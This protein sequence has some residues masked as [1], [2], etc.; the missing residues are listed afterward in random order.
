M[1]SSS[2]SERN[3]SNQPEDE[4]DDDRGEQVQQANKVVTWED[5]ND[6]AI[7]DSFY[8]PLQVDPDCVDKGN[9]QDGDPSSCWTPP[10]S[11]IEEEVLIEEEQQQQTMIDASNIFGGDDPD[12]D[13]TCDENDDDHDV[14]TN[15][16]V[17]D[18]HWGSDKNILRMRNK[19]RDSGSGVSG[20]KEN[21]RPPVFLMPVRAKQAAVLNRDF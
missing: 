2:A 4:K 7:E 10:S 17:M 14:K 19:L 18:K 3:A 8:D 21:R 12:Q 15:K 13:L 1:Q 11:T 9:G 16:V 5:D 6:D 20:W